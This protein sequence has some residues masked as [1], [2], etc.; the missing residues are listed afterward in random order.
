MCFLMRDLR[1]KWIAIYKGMH[2]E[3]EFFFTCDGHLSLIT[4]Q[5]FRDP[6]FFV[7]FRTLNYRK[8]VEYI[9]RKLFN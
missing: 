2:S 9:R 1:Q 8:L 7:L 4:G 6:I 5:N 3:T